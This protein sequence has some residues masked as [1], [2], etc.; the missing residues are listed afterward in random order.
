MKKED[1]EVLSSLA[2]IALTDAE[3]E[4][5]GSEIEGILAYVAE[6]KELADAGIIGSNKEEPSPLHNV[7]REDGESHAP[8]IFTEALLKEA[9]RVERRYVKVKKILDEHTT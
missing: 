3:K 7:F 5:F 1:I 8:G 6:V 2:R 9:P 4:H